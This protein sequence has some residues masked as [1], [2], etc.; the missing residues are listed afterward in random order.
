MAMHEFAWR[1]AQIECRAT[2]HGCDADGDF[3][4]DATWLVLPRTTGVENEYCDHSLYTLRFA[5]CDPIPP[6][7]IVVS[8]I[9]S[10]RGCAAVLRARSGGISQSLYTLTYALRLHPTLKHFSTIIRC[11]LSYSFTVHASE[12]RKIGEKKILTEALYY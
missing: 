6:M 2:H 10:L 8:T 11:L 1:A 4:R 9:P 3:A 7:Y 5:L 12:L